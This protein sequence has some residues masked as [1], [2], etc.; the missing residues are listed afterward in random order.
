MAIVCSERLKHDIAD[1]TFIFASA[2]EVTAIDNQQWLFVHVYFSVNF[3]RQSHLLCI[4]RVK[5]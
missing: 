3:S 2:D 1:A 5:D 4:R